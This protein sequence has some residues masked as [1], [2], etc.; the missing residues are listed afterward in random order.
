MGGTDKGLLSFGDSTFLEKKITLLQDF[1]PEVLIVTNAPERYARLLKTGGTFDAKRTP[2]EHRKVRTVTDKY[3]GAGVLAA[4]YSG[5]QVCG[6]PWAFISTADTPFLKPALIELLISAA[7]TGEVR[8]SGGGRGYHVVLPVW[9]GKIEPLCGIYSAECAD[10][11]GPRLRE[12]DKKIRSFYP[13][14][15]VRYIEEAEIAR[16]DPEGRS[17]IN[18]NTW[19]EYYLYFNRDGS[20]R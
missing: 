14:A 13:D 4:L 17:F 18:I 6:F 8:G 12:G 20:P 19:E 3:P 7:E 2:A 11:I 10:L 9:R 15:R 1:F 16:A 5:L